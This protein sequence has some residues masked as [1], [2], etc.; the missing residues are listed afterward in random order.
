MISAPKE[1]WES[2]P[3]VLTGKN[4]Y[5][6]GRGV[7]DDKGP[8]LAGANF[9][10]SRSYGCLDSLGSTVAT[11]AAELL[12]RRSLHADLVFVIEGEEESGSGGFDEAVRKYRVCRH[13]P[14]R[15]GHGL[16]HL[17]QAQ[18]GKIDVI[19]VR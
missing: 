13:E 14:D 17:L 11:A 15:S 7:T 2:P 12:S 9:C 8:I 10:V 4:G 19:L 3:F 5:L 1:G 6:Y 16:M 18:I